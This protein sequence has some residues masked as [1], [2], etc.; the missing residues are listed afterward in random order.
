MS[1][2]GLLREGGT[3]GREANKVYGVVV[4]IVRDIKDPLNLG[5]VKVDFPWLGEA[6][7]AV[8]ISASDDRAHS[9]WAR[10]VT[11][12]AGKSRGIYIIPEV[13]D[14]V[15]VAFEHG[16][17]DRPF[18]LGSLWNSEDTPPE[19]M[20][21]QGKND[22]RSIHSRSGHK[23]ILNDSDDKPSITIVDKTGENSITID[24]AQNAMAVKVKGD[25]SLDVQG[26][27][28]I[29]AQGK[30]E[31][32]TAQ[33]LTAKTQANLKAS[34]TGNCSI[35][36][37]GPMDVK[38]SAKVTVDGTGQAELKAATVSVNGSGMAEVKGALVKIN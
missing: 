8:A 7:E 10:V 13:G 22:V 4:G 2:I 36:S 38:S 20:D 11:L 31:V 33:D 21:G 3:A 29:K 6:R 25:F 26:K 28:S 23:I 32:E 37:T 19:S 1:L 27:I 35:E 15:L 12:M 14:E 34:A 18:I 24:S 5:R 16:D 30:I 17:L 9:Y